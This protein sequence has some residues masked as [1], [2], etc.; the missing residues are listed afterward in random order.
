[1]PLVAGRDGCERLD[2]VVCYPSVYKAVGARVL[3]SHQSLV[4][5]WR[6]YGVGIHEPNDPPVRA[7][8]QG[9]ELHQN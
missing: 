6:M 5:A 3:D 9:L 2:P 4:G 8:G 1:M 7:S